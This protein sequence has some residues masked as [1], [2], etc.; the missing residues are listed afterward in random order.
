MKMIYGIDDR[1]PIGKLI[2][3]VIQ[4]FLAIVSATITVPV[5]VNATTGATL[6]ISAALVGAGIGT[7]TYLLITKCKS[8]I[9]ISSSFGLIP[10]MCSAFA[11]ATSMAMGY[12]GLIV[13]TCIVGVIYAILALI[14]KFCGTNWISKVFPPVIIGSLVAVIGLSLSTS[15]IANLMSQGF[16]G[17]VCGL[18]A[19]FVTILC[20]TYGK[21]I[22]KIAPFLI[23]I[24]AGYIVA[25]LFGIVDF[26]SFATTVV[27]GTP[28]LTIEL[29]D[30][31]A[32]TPQYLIS[33]IVIYV[34]VS[35]I[36]FAE[37]IAD[38]LNMSSIL[39][40]DLTVEP[41]LHRTLLGDGIATA[42]GGVLSG[43][44]NTTYGES[45]AC[46]GISRNASVITTAAVALLCIIAAMI[47]P[48]IAFLQSIPIS[49]FGGISIAL[50]GFIAVSGLK[51]LQVVDF[52]DNRNIFVASIILVIGIGG[53]VLDFGTVSIT[54]TACAL[55]LGV[56]AN[57]LLGFKKKGE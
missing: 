50:F 15:A 37:H 39:E 46:V 23:G 55:V 12:A 52:E 34:P 48:V 44:G 40:K 16:P 25:L 17:I 38:H 45:I 31:S 24:V 10:A 41:G 53:L 33:L 21:S 6:S 26:T 5:V 47:G 27:F 42:I 51:Q 35:L 20:G 11:G 3:Y 49:I 9:F 29:A 43:I 14:I 18:V 1:P 54:A 8:P 56:L 30:F 13:G 4:L 36:L 22:G 7:F 2:L 32:I 57:I 19:L 28:Q